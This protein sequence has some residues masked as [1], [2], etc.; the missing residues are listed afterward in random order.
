MIE[1]RSFKRKELLF[2][3]MKPITI[4]RTLQFIMI[5]HDKHQGKGSLLIKQQY[6][7][8]SCLE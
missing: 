6:S 8:I 4:I 3:M 5:I 7:K 1:F 2:I